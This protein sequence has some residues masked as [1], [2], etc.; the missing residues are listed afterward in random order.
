MRIVQDEPPH[1]EQKP[2]SPLGRLTGCEMGCALEL[3]ICLK[4]LDALEM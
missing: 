4:N 3:G 2:F 1:Q